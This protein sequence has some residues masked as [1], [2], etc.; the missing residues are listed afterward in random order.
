MKSQHISRNIICEWHYIDMDGQ[1]WQKNIKERNNRILHG[2]GDSDYYL[3]EGLMG[4]L[5][6]KWE[7]PSKGEIDVWYTLKREIKNNVE[8]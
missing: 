4:K 6:S 1:T 5:L 8:K 2:E 3:D 7:A